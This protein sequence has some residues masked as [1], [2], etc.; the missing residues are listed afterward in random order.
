[1]SL[2]FTAERYYHIIDLHTSNSLQIT[3]LEFGAMANA[4]VLKNRTATRSMNLTLK[5]LE[6]KNIQRMTL[7]GR[8]PLVL[9]CGNDAQLVV[10]REDTSF[11]RASDHF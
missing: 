2:P 7:T 11:W 3:T 4:G 5:A 6:A 9:N 10:E 8:N 1:V